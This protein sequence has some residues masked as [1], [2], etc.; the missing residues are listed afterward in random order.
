MGRLGRKAC[1]DHREVKSQLEARQVAKM[2]KA[3]GAGDAESDQGA[4]AGRTLPHSPGLAKLRPSLDAVS[5]L[6]K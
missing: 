2:P 4:R 5:F 6:V 3:L 1:P